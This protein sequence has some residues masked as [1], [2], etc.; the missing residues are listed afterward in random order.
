MNI[1]STVT[2]LLLA[3]W[4]CIALAQELVPQESDVPT[5][6]PPTADSVIARFV[7]AKG[8]KEKL[9]SILSYSLSGVTAPTTHA[10]TF[11]KFTHMVEL[12]LHRWHN[13]FAV[14]QNWQTRTIT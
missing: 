8:G 6:L 12:R 4:S 5:K 7:E 1:Q 11:G 13:I 3:L 2:F 9:S 10:N 14:Q